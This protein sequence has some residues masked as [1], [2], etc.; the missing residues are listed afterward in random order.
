MEIQ[1]ALDNGTTAN[2]SFLHHGVEHKVNVIGSEADEE[3]SS[4]H[5]NHPQCFLSLTDPL[6]S[7]GWLSQGYSSFPGTIC[8]DDHWDHKSSKF[9]NYNHCNQNHSIHLPVTKISKAGFGIVA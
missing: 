7:H 9:G 2:D 3:D 1:R 6:E 8:D 5:E 4:T